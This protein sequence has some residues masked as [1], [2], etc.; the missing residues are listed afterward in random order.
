MGATRTFHGVVAPYQT[1]EEDRTS[2]TTQY[3]GF[4]DKGG[5]WYIQRM[6]IT[7]STVAWTYARGANNYPANWTAKA[8]L[9]YARFDKVGW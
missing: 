6:I 3:F 2:A 9:S 7:G 8:L 4:L 1:S 5:A